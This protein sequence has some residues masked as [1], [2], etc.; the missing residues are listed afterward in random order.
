MDGGTTAVLRRP[1]AMEALKRFDVY[2]KIPKDLT[3]PTT[4]GAAVSIV[5]GLF[6]LTL[7]VTEFMSFLS[8]D[9][10]SELFVEPPLAA[11]KVDKIPVFLNVSTPKLK[12]E[13]LGLDIQDE[14]GRHEVGFS[15]DTEKKE[16]NNGE[17]CLFTTSFQINKVPGNFHLST[18]SAQQQPDEIN[19]GHEVH[20]L[21][22]GERLEGS[23]AQSGAFDAMKGTPLVDGD[24]WPS[25]DYYMKIVPS[26]YQA[27]SGSETRNFQYSYATKSYSSFGH[28]HRV[29][30]AV[31]FRYDMSP[32]T[33]KY[34]EHRQPF[35]HFIT[36]ICAIVGGTFTV[37]GIIDSMIFSAVNIFQ[38]AQIGKL[39]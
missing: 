7:L 9:V 29:L 18:H 12:C 5:S 37:A 31:W 24:G 10:K 27:R 36:T 11:G 23:A 15:G 17:G 22:F 38:K 39:S 16:I 30:P 8:I 35:Y 19:F 13:H 4:T 14:M 34:T 32:I 28:G 20:S 2:R 25:F 26:I 3:Q 6:I 33:V 1:S 21:T